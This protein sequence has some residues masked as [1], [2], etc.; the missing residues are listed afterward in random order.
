MT[1]NARIQA[2]RDELDKL[3][4]MSHDGL[5]SSV[6]ALAGQDYAPITPSR[7]E[8]SPVAVN[9][10]EA[11]LKY[12]A[13]DH[14]VARDLRFAMVA[15]RVGHDY[16]RMY[17]LTESLYKRAV[18]LR[19]VHCAAT[20]SIWVAASAAL[21]F[22]AI[23]S[24]C[25]ADSNAETWHYI[26]K[27]CGNSLDLATTLVDNANATVKA[28]LMDPSITPDAKIEMVLAARHVKRIV[29]L[30]EDVVEDWRELQSC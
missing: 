9:L 10:R 26:N 3:N 28:S 19:D 7:E 14:P 5:E 24:Q 13:L 21:A 29:L 6:A 18:G 16:E 1:P 8:F 2:V 22:H 17:E 11:C 12:V 25:S 30:M 4:K 23:L 27:A 15:I 20:T